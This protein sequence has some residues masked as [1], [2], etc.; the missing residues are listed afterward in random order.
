MSANTLILAHQ[1]RIAQAH[2][3]RALAGDKN[4]DFARHPLPLANRHDDPLIS[5]T[6]QQIVLLLAN[7]LTASNPKV[8]IALFPQAERNKTKKNFHQFFA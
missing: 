5:E 7:L 4:Q 3:D 1:C 2:Q 6:L 8:E